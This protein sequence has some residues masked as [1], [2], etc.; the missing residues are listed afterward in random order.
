MENEIKQIKA[1]KKITTTRLR[2]I[3][4]YYLKMF[5]SSRAN[6]RD[7]LRRRV[8]K[9]AYFDKSFDKNAAY[10]YIEALLDDFEAHKYIDDARFAELKIR[11]YLAVGKSPRYVLGKMREK[12]VD[13]TLALRILEQEDYDP[14]ESAV[15]L[16]KKKKIGPFEADEN[17]RRENRGKDLASLLRAGFDYDVAMKVLDIVVEDN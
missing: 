9:Y 8:N 1:P 16:A 4:L 17:K 11:G 13:E 6:L 2:N 5:E 7:V 15:K 12:G 10:Q 3:A 14:Y